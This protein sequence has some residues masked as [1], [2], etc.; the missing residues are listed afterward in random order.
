MKNIKRQKS[1]A[2]LIFISFSVVLGIFLSVGFNSM[3]AIKTNPNETKLKTSSYQVRPFIHVLNNWTETE[4]AGICTGAG[5]QLNP[6]I[7]RDTIITSNVSGAGILVQSS[8]GAHFNIQNCTILNTGA[9]ATAGGITVQSSNNGVIVGNNCSDNPG[10]GIVLTNTDNCYVLDNELKRNLY[11]G[12]LVMSDSDSNTI[13]NNEINN[14]ELLGIY[15]NI[16]CDDNIITLNDMAGH[17]E[18]ND[19][20]RI[21]SHSNRNT[22]SHNQ[23]YNHSEN[24]I[25]ISNGCN[26]NVLLLN[27]LTDCYQ[28]GINVDDAA[29][30]DPCYYNTIQSNTITRS[31]LHGIYLQDKCEGNLVL[32]NEIMEAGSQGVYVVN[33]CNDTIIMGNDI[34]LSG[35]DGINVNYCVNITITDNRI[36]NSSDDGIQLYRSDDSIAFNNEVFHNDNR[37]IYLDD[38]DGGSHNNTF[39][40]NFFEGNV[41]HAV[42]DVNTGLENFWNITNIGNFWDNYTGS[43]LDDDGLGDTPHP[44]DGKANTYDYLPIWDDGDDIN[45]VVSLNSPP[46]GSSF[47]SIAPTFNITIQDATLNATW[48]TINGSTIKY[49]FSGQT[50]D[51][52]IQINQAAWDALPEG[53]LEIIFYANDSVDNN[54][55]LDVNLVKDYSVDPPEPPP[56]IPFGNWYL[57]ILGLSLLALILVT[58]RKVKQ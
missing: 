25:T 43:D 4:A 47:G 21:S 13:T 7:I 48:Y 55:N 37:G 35:N 28:Y 26:F 29:S 38:G 41:I 27:N 30:A 20:I 12:I 10:S 16:N 32:D 14:N 9:F 22:V 44:I 2:F 24:G 50:G 15:V 34:I 1:R 18:Q 5:T 31:T 57:V 42:D 49:Y 3:S 51:N 53:N 52:I 23:I 54:G 6:Y 36:Y 40:G 45:P 19:G 56:E 33:Q 58:L 17:H 39:Y 46:G 8:I 11:H